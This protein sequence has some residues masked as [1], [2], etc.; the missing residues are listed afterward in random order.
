MPR[1]RIRARSRCRKP[2]GCLAVSAAAGFRTGRTPDGPARM[3]GREVLADRYSVAGYGPN[4]AALRQE[5]L[6]YSPGG[7]KVPSPHAPAEWIAA[8]AS[9][10]LLINSDVQQNTA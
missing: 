7:R 6:I 1:F 10:D 8:A 5:P 2:H 3:G 9:P 4:A